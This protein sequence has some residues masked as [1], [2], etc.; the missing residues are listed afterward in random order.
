MKKHLAIITI[1][2]LSL[3]VL[4]GCIFDPKEKPVPPDIVDKEWPNL[5]EKDDVFKYIKRVYEDMDI[6]HFPKVLDDNFIF[7]FSKTD[8]A[9]GK[10]PEQ[11]GRTE[12]LGS[13]RN[14]FNAFSVE[15]YGSIT[16][17]DLV[18]SPEGLWIE[19]PMTEPPFA[20][21]TWYQKTAE[22]Y[23]IVETTSEW[24][25][26]GSEKKALFTVRQSEVDGEDIYRVVL[27]HDDIQ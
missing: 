12:E 20:G 9:D 8:Y 27:W 6:D 18:I 19:V 14:M 11:W 25:L 16:S 13:A 23:I 24:T 3:S 1:L 26:Q 15:K 7:W 17:I 5:T 4:S 22:Y 10:T 21:E 2:L